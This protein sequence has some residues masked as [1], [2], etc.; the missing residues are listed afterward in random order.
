[1]SMRWSCPSAIFWELIPTRT[2]KIRSRGACDRFTHD[3]ESAVDD[4]FSWRT[5]DVEI[6]AALT[7]LATSAVF[8][9]ANRCMFLLVWNLDKY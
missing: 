5:C 9:A 6:D 2:G 4:L 1:M 7:A 8:R 3:D